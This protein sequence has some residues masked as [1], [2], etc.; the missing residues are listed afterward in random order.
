ME[1]IPKTMLGATLPGNSTVELKE[2]EVPKPGH[3]E[4]LIQTKASTICGSDIRCIY[5]EHVG[6]ARR[7]IF[8][9]WWRGMN[10]AASL[11][12]RAKA[13]GVS[14]KEIE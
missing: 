2:F 12:K 14:K 8:P 4:V 6:K 5:R 11:W 7:D 13:C 3:G 10:P 1:Q 9:E